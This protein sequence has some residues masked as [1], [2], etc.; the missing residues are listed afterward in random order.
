[1]FNVVLFNPQIPQNTGNIART[2]AVTGTDLHLIRPLGFKIDDKSLKRAGLDYWK[3]VNVFVY[4]NFE[5]FL[6]KKGEGKIYLL[7]SKVTNN[8]ADVKYTDGDYLLFG[9]ETSGVPENIH[10]MLDENGV[11][12]PMLDNENARCLNLSNSVN[13][14][15][16]EALRQ[17]GFFNMR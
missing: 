17:N 10:N 9:S 12:I 3:D 13:I 14:V 2:C 11:R 5:D 1:M 4:D 7:S 6:S 8:Y 15:L 16:Y